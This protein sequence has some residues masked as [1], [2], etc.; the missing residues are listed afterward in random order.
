MTTT[1]QATV[2]IPTELGELTVHI[3][4]EGIPVVAWHSLFVDSSSW[5]RLVPLLPGRRFFLIDAPSC[6]DSDALA[7][8]VDIATCARVAATV[9]TAL[10]R[11]LGGLPVDWVGNAWGGHVGIEL[12]ATRPELVRSLVAIS[13]PTFPVGRAVRLKIHALLPLYRLFGPRGPVRSA[14]MSTI[15]TDA[16]RADDPQAVALLDDSLAR[17][18]RRASITAIRTAVLRRTD[19]LGAAR[20][21][22]CPTLFVTTDDRGEWAPE[23]ARDVAEQMVDATEVTVTGSRVIPALE[24]PEQVAAA[25]REFWSVLGLQ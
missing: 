22:T 17:S 23:Q 10:E 20:A 19:L 3:V 18:G 16:T 1:P 2:A 21:L 5:S 12:A 8:P 15:L 11:E 4:G 25:L 13:A 9:L 14:I 7:E 6:G 24:Q